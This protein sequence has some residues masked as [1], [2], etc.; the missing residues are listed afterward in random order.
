[1][2]LGSLGPFMGGIPVS[3]RRGSV[4]LLGNKGLVSLIVLHISLVCLSDGGLDS[5][6]SL[7]K[8]RHH[9]KPEQRLR[10]GEQLPPDA[11]V[12][13]SENN[14][15]V[16]AHKGS[17][18][19][20]LCQVHKDSQHGVI[21]WARLADRSRPYTVLTIGDTTYINDERYA[22][23][24][25]IRHDNWNLRLRKVDLEDGGIYECQA[26]THPPQSTFV[27]LRVD[28]AFAE[29]VGTKDKVFNSGSRLQL[30]CILKLATA[31]PDYIFWYHN[32]RM[33]NFDRDRGVSVQE[34]DSGSTLTMT[35]VSVPDSGNYSCQPRDMRPAAVAV[36]ILSER[37][38]PDALQDK[39]THTASD[40]NSLKIFSPKFLPEIFSP[41]LAT[42]FL[43]CL[44]LW[45]EI[46]LL[47]LC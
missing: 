15:V 39:T 41:I 19:S 37:Q 28:V 23:E 13:L 3:G 46:L 30:I 12:F 34:D 32:D 6:A 21:T 17:T 35:D 4:G 5:S 45:K 43:L 42:T 33:I 25:P 18:T 8:R 38:A 40:G 47:S 24:K 14:T 10:R 2:V 16:S 29:I 36:T 44:L 9:R 7:G 11:S 1:M 31:K 26:T 20:L 27:T 22:I